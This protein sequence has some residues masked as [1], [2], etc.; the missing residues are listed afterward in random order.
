MNR[1]GSF[2]YRIFVDVSLV[3]QRTGVGFADEEE[4][5]K[6]LFDF[7]GP[8]FKFPSCDGGAAA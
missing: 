8:I 1:D 3:N 4:L 5:L 2:N 6:I 7:V